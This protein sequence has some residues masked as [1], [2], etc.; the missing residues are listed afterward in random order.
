VRKAVGPSSVHL[1]AGQQRGVRGLLSECLGC[2]QGCSE[3]NEGVSGYQSGGECEEWQAGWGALAASFR[4][5]G[6]LMAGAVKLAAES[7][8][9]RTFSRIWPARHVIGAWHRH[10]DQSTL[11]CRPASKQTVF[12]ALRTCHLDV[13]HLPHSA[14]S[15]TLPASSRRIPKPSNQYL[16]HRLQHC[17]Y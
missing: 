4:P 15:S 2:R 13:S 16:K 1:R 7:R 6:W 12:N 10:S 9:G 17:L 11:P 14:L 3:V 5:T 8:R